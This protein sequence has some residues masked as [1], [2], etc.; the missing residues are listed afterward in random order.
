MS[1][2]ETELQRTP[3]PRPKKSKTKRAAPLPSRRKPPGA[4]RNS[5]KR[6]S[7]RKKKRSTYGAKATT[8]TLP[9]EARPLEGG[10]L[11]SGRSS[12]SGSGGLTRSANL[13]SR[14]IS[15]VKASSTL[16]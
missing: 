11:Y 13:R 10:F 14:S 12:S 15:R 1:L 9:F 16:P 2:R 7:L 8:A 6:C 3:Q 4:L 5:T